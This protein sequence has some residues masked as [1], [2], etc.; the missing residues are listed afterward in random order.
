MTSLKLTLVTSAVTQNHLTRHSDPFLAVTTLCSCCTCNESILAV[1][2]KFQSIGSRGRGL[3]VI[4]HAPRRRCGLRSAGGVSERVDHMFSSS[5]EYQLVSNY[6]CTQVHVVRGHTG[7]RGGGRDW[8]QVYCVPVV[9]FLGGRL[10]IN[11][12]VIVWRKVRRAVKSHQT[13]I[14][15][16]GRQYV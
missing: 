7:K 1:K 6:L 14:V 2:Q 9:F 11:C 4:D 8:W 15:E 16:V 3:S 10:L 13:S 5:V 12:W